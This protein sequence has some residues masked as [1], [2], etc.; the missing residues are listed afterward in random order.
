[1]EGQVTLWLV[2]YGSQPPRPPAAAR[3]VAVRRAVVAPAARHC[4][5]AA[6]S[7]TCSAAPPAAVS[8]CAAV[9]EGEGGP[10]AAAAP[11][12]GRRE[13]VVSAQIGEARG[14]RMPRSAGMK[15]LGRVWRLK[16]RCRGEGRRRDWGRWARVAT[17]QL[18]RG[19]SGE[20]ELGVVGGLGCGDRGVESKPEAGA[21]ARTDAGGKPA[22]PEARVRSTLFITRY[23]IDLLYIYI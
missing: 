23:P 22:A 19:G 4:S 10:A 1:M 20:G 11:R 12:G 5:A 14:S 16:E 21:P 17:G 9:D 2:G 15:E 8:P 18:L 6:A 3:P 7:R 13:E